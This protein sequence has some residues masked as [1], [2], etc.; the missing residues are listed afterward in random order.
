MS[1][2]GARAQARQILSE[3]RFHGSH[4]PRPFHGV[5]SWLAR[6]LHFAVR[7]WNW[8]SF[9]VGGVGHLWLILGAIAVAVAVYFAL[10]LA[11][12]RTGYEAAAS[13]GR[14]RVGEE[15]P[16]ALERAAE[17]AERR[18]DLVAA[19][20][21]RFRAGLLR[22]GRARVL[23]LRP[24]LRTREAR[25]LLRNPRFDRLADDF[26]EVVYGGRNPVPDD[27]ATARSEWPRLLEEART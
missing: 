19:L 4:L 8:L 3:R 27:V 25:R 1:P 10:G 23:P 17:D 26:D 22:L 16:G 15:D 7:F 11:R 2:A 21:L 20:R 6:H 14:R 13:E 9:E 12:R 24:S 18:G 5:L